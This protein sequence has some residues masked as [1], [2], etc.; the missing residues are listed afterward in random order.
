MVDPKGMVCASGTYYGFKIDICVDQPEYTNERRNHAALK[1]ANTNTVFPKSRKGFDGAN[2]PLV[3]VPGKKVK[4]PDGRIMLGAQDLCALETVEINGN[5]YRKRLLTTDEWVA[6][7]S[8]F[9][10]Q[11]YSTRTGKLGEGVHYKARGTREVGQ[12]KGHYM[13]YGGKEVY[14]MSGNVCEWTYDPDLKVFRINGGSWKF[15]HSWYLQAYSFLSVRPVR[16]DSDIGFRC[17]VSLQDS[18][19]KSR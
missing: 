4:L 1:H 11:K 7:A 5:V 13:E 12:V 6:F 9:R 8:K 10:K 2:H 14:D 17:G 15:P 18:P 19:I 3:D 16:R